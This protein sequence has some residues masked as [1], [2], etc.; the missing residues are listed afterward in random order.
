MAT[1]ETVV[2]AGVF[3]AAGWVV[4]AAN[5]V[6]SG[7]Q[8]ASGRGSIADLGV[9]FAGI[10]PGVTAAVWTTDVMMISSE[11]MGAAPSPLYQP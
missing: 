11:A 4:D 6:Y 10:V 3:V 1:S 8:L 5:I 7:V 2:G 9:A